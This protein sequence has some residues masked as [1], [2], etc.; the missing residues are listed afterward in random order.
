MA[1][2]TT[3]GWQQPLKF[4][5]VGS[6]NTVWSYALYAALLYVGLGFG[7]ASL[8]TILGS[9][10]FG[11]LTQGHL[12]FGGASSEAVGRFIAVWMLIYVI[13]L[14]VVWTAERFGINNYWGGLMATPVVA[15]LSYL[16]QRYFV[17][18]R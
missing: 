3:S 7:L 4:I 5:L 2:D 17:F 14:G 13:Y 6:I 10:A 18:R 16:L 11:F 15:T 1:P 8:V 12:V 9:I